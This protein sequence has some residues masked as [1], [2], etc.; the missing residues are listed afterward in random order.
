MPSHQIDLCVW[1]TEPACKSMPLMTLKLEPGEAQAGLIQPVGDLRQSEAMFLDMK[2]QVAEPAG[3][4][5]VDGTGQKLAKIVIIERR[6][7][8]TATADVFDG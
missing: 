7:V 4:S 6:Q 5:E 3:R 2:D 1:V 8:L